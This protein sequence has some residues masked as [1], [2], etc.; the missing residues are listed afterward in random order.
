MIMTPQQVNAELAGSE[1][2]IVNAEDQAI[3]KLR[4]E[5]FLS[6]FMDQKHR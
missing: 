4:C 5:P 6:D 1:Q 3:A 2:H